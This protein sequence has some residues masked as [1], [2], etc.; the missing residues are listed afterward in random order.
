[1]EVFQDEAGAEPQGLDPLAGE[2]PVPR[3]VALRP[4]RYA[5]AV[6]VHLDAQAGLLTLGPKG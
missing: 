1:M 2:P 6:A 3:R 5:V 4:I